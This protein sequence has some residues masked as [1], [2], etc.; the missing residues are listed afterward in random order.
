MPKAH[1]LPRAGSSALSAFS[2]PATLR[3]FRTAADELALSIDSREAVR[4][5]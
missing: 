1:E 2:A 3:S 4:I 5:R